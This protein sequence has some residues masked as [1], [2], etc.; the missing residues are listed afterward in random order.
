[1]FFPT[2]RLKIEKTTTKLED[3]NTIRSFHY[4]EISLAALLVCRIGGFLVT[5]H[6]TRISDLH[7]SHVQAKHIPNVCVL[8]N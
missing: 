2:Q 1:M 4:E 8:S 3:L 5:G 7:T 6:V